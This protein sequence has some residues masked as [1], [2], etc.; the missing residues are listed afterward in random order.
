MCGIAG[1]NTR[2]EAEVGGEAF[3]AAACQTLHH[4][5]PDAQAHWHANGIG[6]AHT[7]LAIVDL[8]VDGNQPM[9]SACGRYRVVYNGEI[10][11]W[12]ELRV[13]LQQYDV[14]FRTQCDTEVL[15]EGFR[16]WGEGILPKLR[17]MFAFALWDEKERELFCARDTVGKK[18]FV[19]SEGEAGFFF[20]SEI[21]ALREAP[22]V[23]LS[24]NHDALASML[25]HNMRHIPDP[26]T[27][28]KGMRRLPAGHALRVRDG[29]VEQMWRW[30]EPAA[31]SNEP[32]AENLRALLEDCVRLR[33][34][35]DVPVGALLSGGVDSTAIVALMKQ[36]TDQPIRTYALGR[37]ESDEDL[38]RAR[39]MAKHLGT[40]HQ[41]FY[42]QPEAQMA[43]FARLQKIYGEPIML[44]PLAYANEL[45]E[46]IRDDGIKVVLVGHGADELFYGYT[47]YKRMATLTGLIDWLPIDHRM[48]K[49][50]MYARKQ[51][52]WD[53]VLSDNN[54][55]NLAAEQ[56]RYWGALS[57][58]DS[59][60]DASNFVGLMVENTHSVTTAA[61]LPGMAASIE[62]RAP[63]LDKEMLAFAFATHFR[64][65]VPRGADDTQLKA[66]LKDAVKDVMPPEILYASKRG[67]GMGIQERSLIDGAWAQ[68]IRE[69]LLDG[70]DDLD[71]LLDAKKVRSLVESSK[72]ASIIM[73]LFAMQS[74][75]G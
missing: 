14:Q 6:L 49:S 57:P 46:A 54:H 66:I 68:P 17:G 75:R 9:V 43:R 47:G 20:A 45:S 50:Q 53:S 22:G 16:I 5:G 2:P 7:R 37:D 63:F 11:N 55:T 24:L 56:M 65:K 42:F 10:Y 61:D 73:K 23:D 60:I 18:P 67:F 28:H 41:E 35:A 59:L 27:V 3:L 64:D 26:Y 15:L 33:M 71:G 72:D 48:R 30:W 58:S 1:Y 74:W 52:I 19:Y 62:C 13:E 31:S 34:R 70:L 8:S 36:H 44:L 38:V 29:H 21:P 51:S 39:A 32:T 4:R 12:H 25:L 69:Q 40:D